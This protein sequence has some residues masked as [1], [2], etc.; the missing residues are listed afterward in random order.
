[1]F[2]NNIVKFI[3]FIFKRFIKFFKRNKFVFKAF[4]G[5]IEYRRLIS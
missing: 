2:L 3:I 5:V 1:M 4:V